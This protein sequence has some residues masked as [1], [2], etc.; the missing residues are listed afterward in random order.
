[1]ILT[2]IA[3]CAENR[4]IGTQGTLPWDIPE[5]MKFFR[6]STKGHIMIMG[7]KTFDSFGGKPLP[8]R[9]HIVITRK[10]SEVKF[11]AN[12]SSPV[13]IVASVKEAVDLAKTLTGQWGEEVFII[14]GGEV[15]QQTMDVVDKIYLTKIHR[16]FPGD[17]RYPELPK[18][19]FHLV[20]SSPRTG[21]IPFTFETY[22]RV[23]P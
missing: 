22:L 2:H 11:E 10:P 7:R 13:K 3:A 23:R 21:E 18:A 17:T 19:H 14:G 20:E 16:D 8:S 6:D 12:D 1:M 9:Y 5:D 15:Y 4:V